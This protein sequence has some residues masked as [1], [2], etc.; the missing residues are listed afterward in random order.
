MEGVVKLLP[1]NNELPPVS[2]ANHWQALP[3]AGAALKLTVP[4]PQR[5]P[6][7]RLVGAAGAFFT[8]TVT[9][10]LLALSQPV[11]VLY[12]LA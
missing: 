10:T 6:P 3:D 4:S 5:L 9:A 1:V 12:V 8:L 7:A 11:E 2:A